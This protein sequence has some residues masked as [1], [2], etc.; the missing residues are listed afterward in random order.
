MVAITYGRTT[1]N[2]GSL[3]FPIHTCYLRPCSFSSLL[4]LVSLYLSVPLVPTLKTTGGSLSL[5]ESVARQ[6]QL[7]PQPVHIRHLPC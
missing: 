7:E 2:D 4:S 5:G 6:T 3:S 1:F